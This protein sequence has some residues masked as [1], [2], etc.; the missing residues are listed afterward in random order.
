M[1]VIDWQGLVEAAREVRGRAYAPYSNYT[2]GA[3]LLDEQG[4]VWTGCNVENASYGLCICAERSA[5][6]A[7][8][9]AGARSFVALALVTGSSPPATPCGACRQVLRE[10]AVRLPILCANESGE[11]LWTDIEELLP[12]GFGPGDLG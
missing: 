2:V 11:E 1:S 12:H 4:R 5:V 9:S 10:F 6:V 8:V 7:A 3:A